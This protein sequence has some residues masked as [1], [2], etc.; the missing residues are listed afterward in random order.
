VEGIRAAV[1]ELLDALESHNQLDMDEVVS[2]TFSVT[3]DLNAV[4]PAKIARERPNW[5]NVPL[6]DVQQM[7]VEGSL[8]QCIRLLVHFNTPDPIAPIYHPYLRGAKH[9]RPDWVSA[10]EVRQGA[11]VAQLANS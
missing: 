1:H 11:P 5:Q 4:F 7:D 2:V 8:P 3:R 9:L 6:M 10:Q